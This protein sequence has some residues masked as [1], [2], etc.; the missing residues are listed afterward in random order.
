M[1]VREQIEKAGRAPVLGWAQ[2]RQ[3]DLRSTDVR[4]TWERVRRAMN[5]AA[6]ECKQ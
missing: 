1:S 2:D 5:R 3:I 6:K 4:K